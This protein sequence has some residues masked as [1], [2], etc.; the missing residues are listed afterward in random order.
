MGIESCSL[1]EREGGMWRSRVTVAAIGE[2]WDVVAS[3]SVSNRHV[4]RVEN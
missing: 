2:E 4:E 3:E 1:D